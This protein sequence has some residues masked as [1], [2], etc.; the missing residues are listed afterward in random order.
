VNPRRGFT[1][2][3]LLMS[4]A[5]LAFVVAGV[6]LLLV[7]QSLL[8]AKQE[9]TRSLEANG[10]LAMLEVA[11]AVRS[12]GY[13][14][15]PEGAFDFDRY[16]CSTPGTSNTCNGGGRDRANAPDELVVSWRDLTFSREAL[17]VTGGPTSYTVNIKTGLSRP[18]P[19]GRILLLLCDGADPVSY[20]KLTSDA[21]AGATNLSVRTV[22]D[23]DGHYPQAGPAGECFS[24]GTVL[25]VERRRYFIAND[26]TGMSS[27]FRERNPGSQEL[28]Q[29]GIEDLQLTYEIGAPP[30]GPPGCC[31]STTPPVACGADKGWVLGACEGVAAQP[32]HAAAAPDW[33]N[34]GYDS[35]NRYTVHPMN[36]RKVTVNVVAR[37][38]TASP[39]RAGDPVDV[40]GNRPARARDI[41]R[42][43]VFSVTEPTPNMLM[44]AHFLPPY[45]EGGNVG[46]G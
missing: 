43:A 23:S 31:F 25:L 6:S 20:V 37:S 22:E 32:S 9:L 7:Q 5:I 12:A 39:D 24:K 30:P 46:G 15:S 27:L 42:R 18:L 13:G 14:I 11:S 28:V 29:R 26:D 4:V 34:D 44:R 10:R 21:A 38:I 40:V 36:I 19:A 3:E 41:F 2:V 35:A 45:S 16:G 1:L 33:M 17:S 8:S